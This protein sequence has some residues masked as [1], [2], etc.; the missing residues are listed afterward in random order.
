MFALLFVAFLATSTCSAVGYGV[1][2]GTGV[3]SY[4]GDVHNLFSL[5]FSEERTN[6]FGVHLTTGDQDSTVQAQTE[7]N[8]IH[9]SFNLYDDGHIRHNFAYLQLP[10]L[11]KVNTP[12]FGNVRMFAGVG[13]YA[14]L[15]LTDNHDVMRRYD[16]GYILSTGLELRDTISFELRHSQGLMDVSD[17]GGVSMRNSRDVFLIGFNF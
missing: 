10:V 3:T 16:Y 2:M 6:M 17:V 4:S 12:E 15:L 11:V 14:S 7:L 13:P 5:P 8:Y 9:D 1:H